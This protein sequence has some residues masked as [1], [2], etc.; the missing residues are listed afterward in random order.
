[1]EDIREYEAICGGAEGQAL[2]AFVAGRAA[3]MA[4]EEWLT[5]DQIAF[6][7]RVRLWSK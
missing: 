5:Y 2:Q 6:A 3:V 4:W 1:M 7:D